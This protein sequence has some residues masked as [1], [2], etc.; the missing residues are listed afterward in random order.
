MKIYLFIV[1]TA[2][3]DAISTTKNKPLVMFQ[4]YEYRQKGRNAAE[5]VQF[6]QCVKNVILSH[7]YLISTL[8]L[9]W[10]SAFGYWFG[11]STSY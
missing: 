8:E 10:E 4:G 7:F 6:W 3:C 9:S 1:F 2:F 5:T 11:R